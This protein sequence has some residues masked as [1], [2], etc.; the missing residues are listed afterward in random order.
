M[1]EKKVAWEYQC[2]KV[3]D[4]VSEVL[5]EK[6]P[7]LVIRH[8]GYMVKDSILKCVEELRAEE[9]KTIVY[10]NYSTPVYC[11]FEDYSYAMPAVRVGSIGN[12][13]LKQ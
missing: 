9:C 12:I 11:D 4:E 7:D 10:H 8:A 13:L 5:L 1:P 2:R 6:H 3:Y